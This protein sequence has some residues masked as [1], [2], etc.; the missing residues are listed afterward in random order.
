MVVSVV[1]KVR[2]PGLV[3]VAPGSR[4]DD[5]IK[6]AGGATRRSV[7]ASV[8]LARKVSDGEQVAVGVA[9]AADSTGSS[10]G[11]GEG[12][13]GSTS[14]Q[15]TV[16]PNLNTATSEQL[17][18]LPGVGEVTA[19]SIITYR[20]QKGPFKSIEQLDEVDGIGERR[21]ETLRDLVTVG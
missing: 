20:E 4:V 19:Q 3:S 2:H 14:G 12:G 5:A 21:L 8:N 18:E 13:T 11:S 7:L 15:P 6:A 1:G 10:S 17:Q 9:P 16:K